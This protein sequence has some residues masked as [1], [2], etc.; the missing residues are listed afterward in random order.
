MSLIYM[1]DVDGTVTESAK[2]ISEEMAE[3]LGAFDGVIA[4]ISGTDLKELKRMLAP[5]ERH[6]S[7]YIL[8]EMGRICHHSDGITQYSTGAEF[9]IEIA[10]DIALTYGDIAE[11][12]GIKSI[13]DDVVL[14]RETQ[15]TISML[16]RSAPLDEKKRFDP[17]RSIRKAVAQKLV[18]RF[19]DM[20]I[21]I[22][23]TTSLDIQWALWDK[24]YGVDKF[25]RWSGYPASRVIYF[26][27]QLTDGNDSPVRDTGVNW[28]EV[29]GPE[30]TLEYLK[31]ERGDVRF[32]AKVN[33]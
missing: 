22:G 6:R 9:P 29:S 12:M 32:S 24:Y 3:A 30:E 8:A 7:F 26:G 5:L 17:D 25:L 4:F 14:L 23:G 10:E 27:D 15:L 33:D 2:R 16:G 31:G 28:I 11:E 20:F 19:S 13:T 1:L 18:Q 21:T